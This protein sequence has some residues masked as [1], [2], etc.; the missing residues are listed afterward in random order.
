MLKKTQA[1]YHSHQTNLVKTLTSFHVQQHEECV[2]Y[3]ILV[4]IIGDMNEILWPQLIKFGEFE[5]SHLTNNNDF[6]FNFINV[7]CLIMLYTV[8]NTCYIYIAYLPTLYQMLCYIIHPK[9]LCYILSIICLPRLELEKYVCCAWG[10][11][12]CN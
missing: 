12:G 6:Y 3:K 4:M 8:E 10:V 7:E 11:K 9:K 1:T 5:S 2:I